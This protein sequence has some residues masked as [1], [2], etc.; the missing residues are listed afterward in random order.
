MSKIPT[1]LL[2]MLILAS[3]EHERTTTVNNKV[4]SITSLDNEHFIALTDSLHGLWISDSYLTNIEA[5]KSIFTSR[6]YEYIIRGFDLDKHT[7]QTDTAYLVGFTDH[8]GGISSPIRYDKNKGLFVVDSTR[9]SEYSSLPDPFELSYL[10]NNML[11]MYF[12][13][14]N[15]AHRYRK[16]SADLETE[17]RRLLISGNYTAA[18]DKSNIQFEN[19]GQVT[20][21]QDFKYY[22]LIADF[23]EGIE[24]DAIVFFKDMKGG[25]WSDGEIYKYEIEERSL[26]LQHVLTNWETMEHVISDEILLLVRE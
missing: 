3:C 25:N 26:Q 14:T 4:E 20:N 11:K 5:N 9:L 17:F 24:Y 18:Y 19:N 21:F 22:E 1:G 2:L 16:L 12:P 13:N 7:L 6:K 23:G 10:G 8:E 15:T